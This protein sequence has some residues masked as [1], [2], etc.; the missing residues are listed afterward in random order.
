MKQSERFLENAENC[1]QLA[2]GASDRPTRLRYQRMQAAVARLG[3]RTRLVG[4]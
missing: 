3:G 1:A 2:E 4:W